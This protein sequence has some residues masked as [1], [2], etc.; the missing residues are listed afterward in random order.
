MK[1]KGVAEWLSR[2]AGGNQ[3][4][5]SVLITSAQAVTWGEY[6]YLVV[7]EDCIFTV[8]TTETE[9]DLLLGHNDPDGSGGLN[10]AGATITKGMIIVAPGN[11][12]IL[13]ITVSSG[14]VL[15]YG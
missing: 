2:M 1:I 9:R 7:N 3:Q 14:T 15:A 13:N 4:L 8:L 5:G 10:Y 12:L 6:Q 11:E